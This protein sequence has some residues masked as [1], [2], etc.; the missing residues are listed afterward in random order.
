MILCV[1]L[2]LPRPFPT[3]FPRARGKNLPSVLCSKQGLPT[4]PQLKKFHKVVLEHGS[5]TS[6]QLQVH[7]ALSDHRS[8]EFA[9][10]GRTRCHGAIFE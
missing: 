4:W 2:H 3:G 9:F 5:T 7:L 8:S 10:I 6:L 1:L